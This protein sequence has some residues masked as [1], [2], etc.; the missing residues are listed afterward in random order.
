MHCIDEPA[1]QIISEQRAISGTGVSDKNP[2]L[3]IELMLSRATSRYKDVGEE[4][5][6]VIFDRGVAVNIAYAKLFNLPFDHGWKAA[7]QYRANSKVFFTP[8]W[9]EIYTT[10]EERTMSFEA[11][12]AMGDDLRR[13]YQELGYELIDLPLKDPKTRAEFL[14]QYL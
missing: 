14:L 7:K 9:R 8:N 2:S 5:D 13:I 10:D 11:S 4:S 1:R 12:A 3:F 6:I